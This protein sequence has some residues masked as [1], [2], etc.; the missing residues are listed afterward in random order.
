VLTDR[1][2]G[3]APVEERFSYVGWR[4]WQVRLHTDRVNAGLELTHFR[5]L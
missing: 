3:S 4:V 2:P 5:R 1:P